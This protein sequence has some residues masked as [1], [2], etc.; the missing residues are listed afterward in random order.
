MIICPFEAVMLVNTKKVR[1]EHA[2]SSTVVLLFCNFSV[3]SALIVRVRVLQI[4]MPICFPI[5]LFWEWDDPLH[6]F[7]NGFEVLK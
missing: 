7:G 4:S 5:A 2:L 1:D 6:S 3:F